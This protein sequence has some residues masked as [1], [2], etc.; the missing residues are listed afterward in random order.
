VIA[1]WPLQ[2]LVPGKA[3]RVDG[4]I[5]IAMFDADGDLYALDDTCTHQDASLADGTWPV[6]PAAAGRHPGLRT[7]GSISCCRSWA[8]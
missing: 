7:P 3:A 8:A 1:V 6:G 5:P 4:S 2:D